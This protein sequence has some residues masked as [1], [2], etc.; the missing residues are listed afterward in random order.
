MTE[1]GFN[2]VIEKVET[3]DLKR[4]NVLVVYESSIHES[5]AGI[6][7]GRVK[8]RY[9]KP[10]IVL[11]KSKDENKIKGSGR[12]IEEYNMFEEINGVKDLLLALVDIYG[13]RSFVKYR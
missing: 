12:S 11:T 8:D 5:I 10:T 2:K 7:A 4:D 3:T 13:S 9:Y 6:I 1:E